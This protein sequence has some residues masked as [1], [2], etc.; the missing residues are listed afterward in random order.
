MDIL[1]SLVTSR[2]YQ[3]DTCNNQIL[4]R[5]TDILVFLSLNFVFRACIDFDI[6]ATIINDNYYFL[7]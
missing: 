6:M 1:I 7:T 2:L 5:N 3:V 4:R